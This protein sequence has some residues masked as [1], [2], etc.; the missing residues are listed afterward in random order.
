MRLPAGP[1][2][3]FGRPTCTLL[4]HRGY[5]GIMEKKMETIGIIGVILG[6]YYWENGKEN[7][8]YSSLI[9]YILG[10]LRQSRIR[11]FTVVWQ[12]LTG[13][14]SE[15]DHIKAYERL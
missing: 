9:R 2:G 4:L 13:T 6:L 10:L 12:V 14:E 7:G 11:Q 3:V 15:S 1:S 8:N 5:I